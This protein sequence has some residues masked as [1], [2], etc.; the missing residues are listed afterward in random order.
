MEETRP[1][2]EMKL[3]YVIVKNQNFAKLSLAK[4]EPNIA[5]QDAILLT[6]FECPF[7]IVLPIEGGSTM[8]S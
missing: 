6:G 3:K 7:S 5:L 1:G 4:T 8:M 2:N